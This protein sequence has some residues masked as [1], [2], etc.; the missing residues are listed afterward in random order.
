MP[1]NEADLAAAVGEIKG[2]MQGLRDLVTDHN[3]SMN[4]RLDDMTTSTNRRLDDLH[5]SV[6]QRLDRQQDEIANASDT[7]NKALTMAKAVKA[8]VEALEGTASKS[9]AKSGVAGGSA[10]GAAVAGL[11]ELVKAFFLS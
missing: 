6:T 3:Q 10:A 7:A 4:R 8:K 9:G 2:L 11:L 5:T 1:P